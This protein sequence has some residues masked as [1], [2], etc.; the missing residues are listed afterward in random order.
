M[1]LS[2][3]GNQKDGSLII[4]S[5]KKFEAKEVAPFNVGNALQHINEAVDE[6]SNHPR[7]II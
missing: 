7:K 1:I 6:A 5:R 4:M 2:I 3:I